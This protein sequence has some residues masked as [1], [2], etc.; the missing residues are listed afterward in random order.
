[1]APPKS[2]AIPPPPQKKKKILLVQTWARA[3][4]MKIYE[5]ENYIIA[6][7]PLSFP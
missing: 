6:H 1:M 5:N 7:V 3:I 4:L 2:L